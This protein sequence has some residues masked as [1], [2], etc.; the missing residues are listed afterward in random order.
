MRSSTHYRNDW[1][2]RS[3]AALWLGV[4]L[5]LSGCNGPA[6]GPGVSGVT[7]RIAGAAGGAAAANGQEP[8]ELLGGVMISTA[9][10]YLSRI[11]LQIVAEGYTTD[12]IN[13]DYNGGRFGMAEGEDALLLVDTAF[14]LNVPNEVDLTFIVTA[15]NLDGYRVFS[16]TSTLTSAQML[17]GETSMPIAMRVD[18]DP[19]VPVLATDAGCTGDADGDGLCDIYEDLFIGAN[20]TPD[21]DGDGLVNSQDTD[22]DGDGL[23]DDLDG[24]IPSNDGYPTFIHSNNPPTSVSL[25]LTTPAGTPVSGDPVVVDADVND[26]HVNSIVTQPANGT[27]SI[28]A[29]GIIDPANP[30]S[31]VFYTVRY[32]PAP[33]FAGSDSFIIRSTDRNGA[34]VDGTV[35]VTVTGTNNLPPVATADSKATVVDVGA[36][37]DLLANDTDAEGD[38]F[39]VSALDASGVNGGVVTDIGGGR[40]F[41]TPPSGYSGSDN[42][43]YTIVDGFGRTSSATVTVTMG[44]DSDG[45]GLSDTAE[46]AAGTSSAAVDSD[47]D[48]FSDGH[49]VSAGSLP[50][51]SASTPTGTVISVTSGNYVIDTP[52]VWGLAGS[53]Y[54]VQSNVAVANGGTLTIEPGVAV[55]F[56]V[57]T[58][59]HFVYPAG[60][61]LAFGSA[62]SPEHVVFTSERDDTVQ[63]DTNGDGPSTLPG[64]SDWYH[65]YFAGGEGQLNNVDIRYAQTSLYIQDA[66]PVANDLSVSDCGS[67]CLYIASADSTIT[68]APQFNNVALTTATSASQY[69]ISIVNG[70]STNTLSPVFSGANT[71]DLL[72]SVDIG[73]NVQGTGAVPSVTGFTVTGGGYGLRVTS[74]AAGSYSYNTLGQALSGGVY[75]DTTGS[76]SFF[77]NTIVANGSET[78][79]GAGINITATGSNTFI[80]SNLVRGNYGVMGGGIY[81]GSAND[82]QIRN[83]LI[84]DNVVL[85]TASTGG[86]GIYVAP[87]AV[88]TL[89]HNT[90]SGNIGGGTLTGGGLYVDDL[91]TITVVD[92]IFAQNY[93]PGDG[94]LDNDIDFYTSGAPPSAPTATINSSNNLTGVS[95]STGTWLTGPGDLTP[96]Q[97]PAFVRNWYLDNVLQTSPAINAGSSATLPTYL[98]ALISPTTVIAGTVDTSAGDS[99][100]MGY[101]HSVAAQSVDEANSTVS[102]TN[103]SP[104]PFVGTDT[105]VVIPVDTS[106]QP[107][108]PGH[109]VTMTYP[110]SAWGWLSGAGVCDSIIGTCSFIDNGDGSYEITYDNTL[111]GC[112]SACADSFQIMING[113]TFAATIAY[114][115][116]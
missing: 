112:T 30:Y 62:A 109:D 111:S 82:P 54:W 32:D 96:P 73:I 91:A 41:Y 116:N 20:G 115:W 37:V 105:V 64:A 67:Y 75:I 11:T 25:D 90:L 87:S 108:G 110:S 1:L 22:S 28:L 49:E 14:L 68:T 17:S 19:A 83:N 46:T 94:L 53:P 2:C 61:L 89:R 4:S 10:P 15:Y 44:A 29:G 81:V 43:S 99:V 31:C 40:V 59:T 84:L 78:T 79:N 60:K 77:G 56:L 103:I 74:G 80:D 23:S 106:G 72:N 86:G 42:F 93:Y 107:M 38:A 88:V 97:D 69:G 52:T 114:T 12:G 58:T 65:I 16:A 51:S 70:T 9:Y 101:H 95:S 6:P 27:A 39:T 21:I 55:K 26:C 92:N 48:G 34:F 50:N 8:G 98:S 13:R 5:L 66:S 102:Y 33:G 18:I 85:D 57:G 7:V 104:S 35:T 45:D 100:D 24:N 113:T 76:P 47:G 3:V 36:T 63:G 71:I